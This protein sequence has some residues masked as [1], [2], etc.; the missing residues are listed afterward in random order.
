MI[1]I[2]LKELLEER[3][4]S[5]YWLHQESGIPYV[6]IQKMSKSNQKSVNLSV[7][8]RMCETLK[9]EAGDIIQYIPESKSKPSR[10]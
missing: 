3:D 1:R 7:L 4:K 5:M 2:R 10:K 6:T 9:C 8:D